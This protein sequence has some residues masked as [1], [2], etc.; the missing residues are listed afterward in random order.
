[1]KEHDYLALSMNPTKYCFSY[2]YKIVYIRNSIS[3]VF[4]HFCNRFA[5]NKGN[6]TDDFQLKHDCMSVNDYKLFVYKNE[7]KHPFNE[8]NIII[9]KEVS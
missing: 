5:S 1:M 7:N 8:T 4:C 3:S 2:V 9:R 6:Y